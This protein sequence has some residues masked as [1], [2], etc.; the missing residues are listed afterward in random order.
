MKALSRKENQHILCWTPSGKAFHIIKPKA[1]ATEVL[2][3][4]FKTSKYSS[5]TR[6]LHRW[7]FSRH[8][9]GEDSGAYYHEL[10]QRGRLDLAEKMACSTKEDVS[11][12]TTK[13][14]LKVNPIQAKPLTTVPTGSDS[15]VMQKGE[16]VSLNSL[17]PE[18]FNL[19]DR[20]QGASLYVD[21]LYRQQLEMAVQEPTISQLDAAI[22]SE[23]RRRIEMALIQ[24]HLAMRLGPG[25]SMDHT[26]RRLLLQRVLLGSTLPLDHHQQIKI[27][28]S[29]Q[30]PSFGLNGLPPTNIQSAK[31]A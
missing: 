1:F 24:R 14:P 3:I 26:A 5:F 17:S 21:P 23:V 19:T 6:K 7:G 20:M 25:T 2:P 22:E 4:F 29:D 18:N 10:F 16:S 8:F 28:S 9:R 13:K 27:K 12:P 31:T 30:S 15:S 11:E